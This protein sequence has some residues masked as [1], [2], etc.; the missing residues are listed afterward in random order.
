MLSVTTVEI[1]K[2]IVATAAAYVP[3]VVISGCFAAWVAKKMGDSTAEDQGFLTLN[4]WRHIYPLGLG[5]LILMRVVNFPFLFG[6]GQMV[7]LNEHRI[8]G[9]FRDLKLIAALWARSMA[10]VIMLCGAILSFILFFKL[11]IQPYEL[12]KLYPAATESFASLYLAFRELNLMSAA[13][14]MLWGLLRWIIMKIFPDMQNENIFLVF[15]VEIS[16][17][18]LLWNYISPIFN[19]IVYGI[20]SLFGSLV[21]TLIG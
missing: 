2:I 13:A 14:Y 17:L 11:A 5:T 9:R 3:T 12:I 19:A 6:F 16:F 18:L 20:E 7:P 8:H 4:P 10:N 15:M 21:A 1:I